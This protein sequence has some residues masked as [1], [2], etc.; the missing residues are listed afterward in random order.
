M[1]NSRSNRKSNQPNRPRTLIST[2]S[3]NRRARATSNNMRARRSATSHRPQ[4]PVSLPQRR[5][6]SRS[7]KLLRVPSRRRNHS[8]RRHLSRRKHHSH[9]RTKTIHH[10]S[11]RRNN[12]R[13]S[14]NDRQLNPRMNPSLPTPQAQIYNIRN[15]TNTNSQITKRIT[16]NLRTRQIKLNPSMNIISQYNRQV[17]RQ[18]IN[19]SMMSIQLNILLQNTRTSQF[20]TRRLTSPTK[21]IIRIASPSKLNKTCLRT[22]QLRTLIS[23]INT[24]ITLNH[25]IHILISMGNI[26]QT[27]LRTRLT[28]ST[29]QII[30][31]SSPIITSRR[32]LNKTPLSTKNINTIIT[33]RSHRLTN[34]IQRNTL[35][36]MLRPNTRLTSQSII[37]NLTNSHTNITTSTNPLISNRTMTRYLR[38]PHK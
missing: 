29:R 33:T 30:R 24:R 37:L 36:S 7:L 6:R 22:H 12:R 26:M 8:R 19:P 25:N 5:R 9:R 17:R 1:T 20:S 34:Q 28:T 11:R 10:R 15:N 35:I 13:A 32:N 18:L 4:Y 38:I 23:T 2:R 27:N 3:T 31:I 14:T 21:Q 16:N